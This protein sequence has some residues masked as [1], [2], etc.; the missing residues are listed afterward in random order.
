MSCLKITL[1]LW[2]FFYRVGLLVLNSSK[3]SWEEI[4]PCWRRVGFL[5]GRTSSFSTWHLLRPMQTLTRVWICKTSP[6]KE[7]VFHMERKKGTKQLS[8]WMAAEAVEQAGL[9]EVPLRWMHQIELSITALPNPHCV[10]KYSENFNI[11]FP[12][13]CFTFKQAVFSFPAA[14]K[15]LTSGYIFQGKS[16]ILTLWSVLF[17]FC[18][19]S[20]AGT[21]TSIRKSRVDVFELQKLE[22]LQVQFFKSHWAAVLCKPQTQIC[23]GQR[24]RK[25]KGSSS[26][27]LQH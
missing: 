26:V 23:F 10:L 9:M 6:A 3:C 14:K 27:R 4:F 16:L 2:D 11:F 18:F 1:V 12:P 7:V 13:I 22:I 15:V 21:C 20:Y 25:G 24:E 8:C 5:G 19:V 17:L